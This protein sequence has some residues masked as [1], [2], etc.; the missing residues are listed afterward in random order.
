MAAKYQACH[1]RSYS[2][3]DEKVKLRVRCR[4]FCKKNLDGFAHQACQLLY[5]YCEVASVQFV[6]L[7]LSGNKKACLKNN[8]ETFLYQ[9]SRMQRKGNLLH[10]PVI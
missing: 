6:D 1:S 2:L 5:G 8:K 3:E 7:S 10:P 9:S 4:T